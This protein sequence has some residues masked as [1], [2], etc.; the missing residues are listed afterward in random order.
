MKIEVTDDTIHRAL[1]VF[2]DMLNRQ[3]NSQQSMKAALE[4]VFDMVNKEP[5]VE[6]NA[7]FG[8]TNVLKN[9]PY[10][11]SG[12]KGNDGW[13]WWGGNAP[14]PVDRDT[15]VQVRFSTGLLWTGSADSVNWF[16]G[17]NSKEEVVAYRIVE[18]KKTDGWMPLLPTQKV[19]APC[20]IEIKTIRGSEN[21]GIVKLNLFNE[22]FECTMAKNS[23]FQGFYRIIPSISRPEKEKIPTLKE[24]F[25]FSQADNQLLVFGN[26]LSEY[27]TKYM[28]EKD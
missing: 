16:Y 25:D 3:H 6:I 9:N 23:D 1:D 24:Y 14:C 10:H 20:T 17:K 11:F 12:S 15:M 2:S 18:E 26:A 27:L 21:F 22:I 13:I 19:P 5:E 7:Q 4:A 28:K 8:A